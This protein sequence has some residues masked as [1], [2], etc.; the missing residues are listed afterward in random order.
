[1]E[2][3]HPK[4]CSTEYDRLERN[5]VC[6]ISRTVEDVSPT[7]H[8]ACSLILVAESTEV[9][10]WVSLSAL[11]RHRI[12]TRIIHAHRPGKKVG[13]VRN[14]NSPLAKSIYAAL[15]VSSVLSVCIKNQQNYP[16]PHLAL[17]PSGLMRS[18]W[19]L[20]GTV[21]RAIRGDEEPISAT[22]E[23]M[24]KRDREPLN[25]IV[26]V[27]LMVIAAPTAKKFEPSKV[28]DTEDLIKAIGLTKFGVSL[29]WHPR[30]CAKKGIWEFLRS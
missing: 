14:T 3:M 27:K 20:S 8:Q 16:A 26:D 24:L 4:N 29:N 28:V 7:H 1:M 9:F 6:G 2:I 25:G 22:L 23:D 5:E 12:L 30:R 18:V 17:R 10:P 15:S 21:V 13:D 11:T 19:H